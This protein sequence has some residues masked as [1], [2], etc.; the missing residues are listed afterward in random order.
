MLSRT[1]VYIDGFNLFYGQ[2]KGTPWKWLNLEMLFQKILGTQ[3]RI[4]K[5]KFFTARVQPTPIDPDLPNRQDAY[6][7]ALE[8]H[9]PLV[10]IHYGHFLCHQVS[11]KHANPP[12]ATVRVWKNEEKG[13]DVNM[14]LE[15]L[16]D[17]WLDSYDCAVVVSNDS[18]LAGSLK[19]IKT[20]HRKTIGLIT[21]GAPARKTSKQLKNYADFMK[22]IRTHALECSQLP[23][24]SRLH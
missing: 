19:L 24:S 18:D 3:N 22:S 17:A 5:I 23:K 10:E 8:S 2:L 7:R 14:A 4:I 9:C 13:S 6:L 12:P 15:M 16:N 21:P 1:I 20:Q 11:M